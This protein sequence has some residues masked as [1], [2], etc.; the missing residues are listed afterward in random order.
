M[1]KQN[2]VTGTSAV[3]QR[4]SNDRPDLGALFDGHITREFADQDVDATMGTMVPEPYVQCVPTMTGGFGGHSVRYFYSKHFV[5]QIPKDAKVTPIS[6]TIGKDQVVDELIVS[7][8]HDAQ[9]DYILPGIPPTGKRVEIPHVVV[10]KFENGKVA[11][12]HIYWDQA[13]VLVQLGLLDRV[14][15]P[16]TGAEQARSLVS[17]AQGDS[18]AVNRLGKTERVGDTATDFS[19]TDVTDSIPFAKSPGNQ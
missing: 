18:A 12:E 3:N 7:F 17:V 6:R 13:S 15:L 4:N 1:K 10:M 11:H 16:V 5:N 8:T 2:S 14:N 19:L 9:W